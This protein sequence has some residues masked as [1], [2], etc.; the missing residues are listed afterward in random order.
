MKISLYMYQLSLFH[1]GCCS[2]TQYLCW[3]FFWKT[4]P[5]LQVGSSNPLIQ[6]GGCQCLS[7]SPPKFSLCIWLLLC[8][9]HIHLQRICLLSGFFLL[10]LWSDLLGLSLWPFFWS[11][12]C[13]IWV[14]LPLLFFPSLFAWKICFQPFTFS[15][16]RFLS[17]D[18]SLV[19]SIYVGYVFLSIQLFYIF[20]LEHLI[21]LHLRLLLIGTYSLLIFFV[22]MYLSFSLFSFL[23][24][25]QSY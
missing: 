17:W 8:W 9:V 11:L 4:C 23:S 18:R 10:V 24:L 6:L 15:L 7:C 2:V 25:K 20:W 14:L 3:Y 19:G 21:H 22:P 13:L 5:F 12:C 1:L 16:C